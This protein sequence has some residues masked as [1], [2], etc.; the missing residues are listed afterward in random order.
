MPDTSASDPPALRRRHWIG[1]TGALALTPAWLLGA[2]AAPSGA[3][4]VSPGD[5][6]PDQAARLTL[7]YRLANRLGWGANDAELAHLRRFGAEAYLTEQLGARADP[8]LPAA[9]QA[10]IDALKIQRQPM[11]E[12]LREM[13]ALRKSADAG[14][15]E[16]SRKTARQQYQQALNTLAG[17]AA[18]RHLLRALHSRNQLQER[19]TW[20]WFNHFNVHQQKRD[21]RVM[22]ADYEERAIRPYALGSLRQ[23]L[24][25]VARHPAMLR[26][27]DNDQNAAGRLNEN[28]ARELLELHTLGIDGG[29]TQND[30]Q[31][32]ARVLTGHGVQ[33]NDGPPRLNKHLAALHVREG[34]YEFHPG[35]HDFGDKTLLGR[36]IRGRGAAELDEVLD[37]LA[38]HPATARFV[39][40]K[41]ARH[42]LSD[43]PPADLIERM[44]RTL[45][46]SG[47]QIGAA[48]GILL[49]SPEF[50]GAPVGQFKDPMQFV[51]SAV[52]AAY[53]ERVVLNTQPMQNWLNRLGEGLYNR[54]TPDG[55]P[56]G[57][58]AWSSSG[59]MAMRFEIAGVI[60]AGSA[61]LFKP[62]PAGGGTEQPAFPQLA[63]PIYY[64]VV[65]PLLGA[66]TRQALDNA[67]TPQEWNTL[68][69]ASPEFMYR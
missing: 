41:L 54:Q 10:Q 27:L 21:V 17:Q 66:D 23:L 59:Q 64:Q 11:P 5:A 3:P 40:A 57:A 4:A 13:E 48:L 34:A 32:L 38:S 20:F 68:Y 47:G 7:D 24:G 53:D 50:V 28:Y 45:L 18:T 12:L 25:A 8:A 58:E 60:G 22:L 65:R 42:L 52:R 37:L 44:A 49:R 61:G 46:D 62:D 43:A 36:T 67:A 35:R 69:L 15:D 29:Y 19:M 56:S 33:I 31:E 6:A 2:C 55:Y 30:V 39:S 14:A 63:R 9:A 51:V 16:D 26:Y 1:A